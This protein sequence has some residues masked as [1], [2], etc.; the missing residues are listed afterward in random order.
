MAPTPPA[1][2]PVKRNY[3]EDEPGFDNDPIY[4]GLRPYLDVARRSLLAKIVLGVVGLYAAFAVGVYVLGKD[5]ARL[6]QL[7]DAFGAVNATFSLLTLVVVLVTLRVQQR[8][9][10]EQEDARHWDSYVNQVFEFIRVLKDRT[11]AFTY[12]RNE[13]D[14]APKVGLAGINAL[15]DESIR[16]VNE[17]FMERLGQQLGHPSKWDDLL[18]EFVGDIERIERDNGHLF[19]IIRHL[20]RMLYFDAPRGG[21]DPVWSDVRMIR[22]R[23]SVAVM[24]GAE[25]LHVVYLLY[26]VHVQR[27]NLTAAALELDKRVRY[28]AYSRQALGKESLTPQE[29]TRS[30]EADRTEAAPEPYKLGDEASTPPTGEP[31]DGKENDG[32]PGSGTERGPDAGAT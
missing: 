18:M 20:A 15:S 14:P 27:Y 1:K 22:L 23:D 25:L 19:A 2:P 29:L 10:A 13:H 4:Q 24:I 7:G 17:L 9:L 8:E 11:D 26:C 30:A 31:T 3:W 32:T 28:S 16:R 6:G 21:H 5:S 12:K